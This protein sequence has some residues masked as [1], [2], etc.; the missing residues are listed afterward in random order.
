VASATTTAAATTAAAVVVVVVVVIVVVVVVWNLK[1]VFCCLICYQ[2]R[3]EKDEIIMLLQQI[4]CEFALFLAV[5]FS[6]F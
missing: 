4:A 5:L 3:F 6:V 1:F 2:L